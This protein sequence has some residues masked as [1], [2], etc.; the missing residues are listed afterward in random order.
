MT[1]AGEW[2]GPLAA[3]G[4]IR[5]AVAQMNGWRW[6]EEQRTILELIDAEMSA[7][8]HAMADARPVTPHE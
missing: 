5:E 3:L 6:L 7:Y 8:T 4:R 2:T 1:A